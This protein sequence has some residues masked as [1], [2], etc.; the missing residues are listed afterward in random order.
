MKRALIVVDVQ[1]EYVAGNLPITYPPLEKS[2]Q[3]IGEAIDAANAN[4][5]LVVLIQQIAPTTSPIFAE[6]SVGSE[7]HEVATAR[8]HD[9]VIAKRL[10]NSFAGTNLDGWLRE[11][12]VDTVT[13]VGYMTHH[14][15]ESTARAAFDLGYSVE[16]LSD[17]TGTLP[18]ANAAASIGAEEMHGAFLAALHA[19]FAAVVPTQEWI[20]AMRSGTQPLRGDVFASARAVRKIAT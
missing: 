13:L 5:T 17:A 14:C 12:K 16:V 7:I 2:L 4:G 9:V 3:H 6:G 10:P 19:R 15:V 8:Q 11:R 1:N 18:Y 20:S